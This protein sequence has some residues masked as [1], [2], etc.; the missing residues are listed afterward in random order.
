METNT[1]IHLHLFSISMSNE[2]LSGFNTMEISFRANTNTSKTAIST[3]TLNAIES[4]L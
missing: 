1:I 2:A 3:T 4:R